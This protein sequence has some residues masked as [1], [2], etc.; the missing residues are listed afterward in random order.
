MTKQCTRCQQ[1]KPMEGFSKDKTRPDG[2]HSVCKE[3]ISDYMK[4]YHAEHKLE[5]KKKRHQR[6][7]RN[8]DEERQKNK[9]NREKNG[10]KWNQ[11]RREK[12]KQNPLI[13]MCRQAKIRAKKK[14]LEFCISPSSLTIPST[15]PVLGIPLFV[16]S[17][18]VCYNSPTLDRVDNSKGYVPGNVV[19]VSFKANTIKNMA[20]IEELEKV[21]TFY[22]RLQHE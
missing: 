3:C 22:K 11:T 21:L 2:R 7:I 18:S 20:S 17:G 16:S 9:E 8:R 6:Y 4:R 10:W 19:I 5:I 12:H 14:G 1:T 15:C 13:M